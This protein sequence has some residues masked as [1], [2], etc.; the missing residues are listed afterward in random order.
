MADL[1]SIPQYRVNI[2]EGIA[3]TAGA[4]FLVAAGLAGLSVKALSNAFD[5]DRAEA[6]AHSMIDYAIPGSSRGL[7]GSNIGGGKMAV[8]GSEASVTAPSET[9]S[10]SLPAVELAIAQIPVQLGTEVDEEISPQLL[11]S[12]F[13]FSNQTAEAFQVETTRTEDRAFCGS[14]AP[15][16]IQK[17]KLTL[18]SQIAPVPAVR[19]EIKVTVN[20]SDHL[21]I[22]SAAGPQAQENAAL[23]FDSLKCKP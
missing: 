22:V 13:S 10:V 14:I 15:L 11:F 16:T 18:A 9:G 8:I 2:W 6:I 4:V 3:I 17:G 21:A 23:V 20:E 5:A 12:G 1:P 7:F 19:Y